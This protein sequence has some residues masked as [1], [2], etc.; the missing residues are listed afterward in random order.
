VVERPALVVERSA[1][2]V[3]CKVRARCDGRKSGSELPHSK[4]EK[5]RVFALAFCVLMAPKAKLRLSAAASARVPFMFGR[6]IF[7]LF[8]LLWM[9]VIGVIVI[10]VVGVIVVLL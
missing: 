5:A 2:A 3:R 4:K 9:R 10:G 6:A 7:V 8:M 1:G